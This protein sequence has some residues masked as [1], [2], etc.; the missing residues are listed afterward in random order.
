MR[1]SINKSRACVR[2][3][4]FAVQR[5]YASSILSRM[6]WSQVVM[7][8]AKREGPQAIIRS[9]IF[10]RFRHDR[11]KRLL[12]IKGAGIHVK[13][14]VHG[15]GTGAIFH[16]YRSRQELDD[17]FAGKFTLIFFQPH[18]T[19]ADF[20]NW[21][22]VF[23]AA[24]TQGQNGAEASLREGLDWGWAGRAAVQKDACRYS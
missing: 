14:A 4:L 6:K 24:C 13:V 19:A 5:E 17:S 18:P 20:S 9:S 7:Y 10:L 22:A 11:L 15:R 16:R 2:C 1:Q 8:I 12:W 21:R 23:R 3:S